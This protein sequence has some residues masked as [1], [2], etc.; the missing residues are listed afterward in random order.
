MHKS[1]LITGGCGFVGANLIARL[2]ADGQENIRV[3]DNQSGGKAEWISEFDVDFQEGDIRNESD[4]EKA[5]QGVDCVVH[6]AADTRVMDSIDNPAFNWDVNVR[7]T[8]N[9][10]D[11]MRRRGIQRFVNA[12][13]GGAILGEA[14]PPVNEEM[15]PRPTSPYGAAKLAV[16]G[17]CSAFGAAYGMNAVSLR[18]FKRLRPTLLSQGQCCRFIYQ[19]DNE[20]RR[21]RYLWRRIANTRLCIC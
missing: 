4:V 3:L 9:V 17:Y 20:W 18:F 14:T 5:L 13:T 21:P 7:G 1:V 8:F 12:S 15:P 11:T 6:L 19:A 16:E 2:R 10:I